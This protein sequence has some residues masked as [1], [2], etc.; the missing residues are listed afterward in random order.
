MDVLLTL[1]LLGLGIWIGVVGAEFAI[2][3]FGTT[4]DAAHITASKLH[5]ITDVWV[6]IPAFSL[7]LI[8]GLA[9][10]E[11]KDLSGLFIW[12]VIFG[13]LAIGFNLICV[14]AVFKRRRYALAGDIEGMKS[15]NFAMKIGGG[16]IPAFLAAFSLGMFFSVS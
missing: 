9:M 2:E 12:K 8:T 1:H 3:H 4:S 16:V 5:Y 10:L 11:D 15:T 6:E 13:L 14:Y 7:V